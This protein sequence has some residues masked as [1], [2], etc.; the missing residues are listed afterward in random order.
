MD[1]IKVSAI[2]EWPQPCNWK[3]VQSFLRFTNF[4]CCFIEGF[5][6]VAR[7]L[8]NLTKKDVPF[9]WMTDCEAAFREL[10]SWIMSAPILTLPNDKQPFRVKAN[11]LDF[12]SGRV[13]LQPSEEDKKWHLIAFL[14]KSLTSVQQNYEVHDKELLA[15]I[16]CLQQWQHFLKGAQHPVEIWMDHQNPKYFGTAHDL[17]C[18][19]A[20]WSLF[21]S[22]FNYTLCHCPGSS[23]GEPDVRLTIILIELVVQSSKTYFS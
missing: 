6:S 17:N 1:P 10:R 19:Q 22:W 21:L 11:S 4:Y 18:R 20:R 5:S 16:R 2:V 23:M 15:I 13:L 8:F 14:S 9:I 7:L 3:E 12:A